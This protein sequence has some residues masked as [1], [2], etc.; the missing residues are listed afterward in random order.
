VRDLNLNDVIRANLRWGDARGRYE[1]ARYRCSK[2]PSD[3]TLEAEAEARKLAEQAL[4]DW[5]QAMIGLGIGPI[6]EVDELWEPL[7]EP[8]VDDH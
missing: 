8:P 2:D 4:E 3:A 7:D 5:R 1:V 6:P